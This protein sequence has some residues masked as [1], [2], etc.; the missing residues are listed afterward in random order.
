M[1]KRKILRVL[2][3]AA[4]ILIF[5][6][7]GCYS[8]FFLHTIRH[9]TKVTL[10]D[11]YSSPLKSRLYNLSPSEKTP[12]DFGYR[13]TDESFVSRPSGLSL[14]G[15]YMP[16]QQRTGKCIILVHGRWD[17]RLKPMK[18]LEVLR[19]AGLNRQY[20]VFLPDLRNAGE[21]ESSETLFGYD[22]AEDIAS[23]MAHCRKEHGDRNF[24]IYAFSH[25]A[26]GAAVAL[27]GRKDVSEYMALS[28]V[29]I[30]R[31]ILDSPLSD[32]REN[33]IGITVR[34]TPFPRIFPEL[35]LNGYTKAHPF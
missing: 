26:M 9:Y 28:G 2:L 4:A 27:N 31:L 1:K 24:I 10:E 29:H 6:Y 21:S 18:Y 11:V 5:I 20:A 14:K 22:F 19:S 30:D 32:A 16:A 8:L 3:S 17:N 12:S 15:W 33:M 23:A 35:L 25:G 13:Y 34:F 7:T